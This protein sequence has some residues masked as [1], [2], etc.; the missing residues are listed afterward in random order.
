MEAP[1]LDEE[2]KRQSKNK[3]K[4][5]GFGPEKMLFDIQEKFLEVL[6]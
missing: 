1:R 2:V 3:G 5:P 6:T 4:Y